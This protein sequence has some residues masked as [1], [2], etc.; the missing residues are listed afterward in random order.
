MKNGIIK[1]CIIGLIF[2][3]LIGCSQNNNYE[4]KW[5]T[6]IKSKWDGTKSV[7]RLDIK[8]NGDNFIINPETEMYKDTGKTI[9][10]MGKNAAWASVKGTSASAT[11]KDGKLMLNPYEGFTYVKNDG[12]LLGANGEIYKKETPDELNQ[13]KKDATEVFKQIKPQMTLQ[14]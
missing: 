1:T 2:I 8:K 12:T 9:G 11:L 3:G 14:Q 10:E 4:G 6:S 13:L 7:V 5:V